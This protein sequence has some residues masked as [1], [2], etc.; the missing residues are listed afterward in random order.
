MSE[1]LCVA[2][3]ER[4]VEVKKCQLCRKCYYRQYNREPRR[5]GIMRSEGKHGREIEFIKNYFK[6]NTYVYSPCM[7]NLG[8]GTRYTPDFYDKARNVFIEVV[9]TRQAYSQNKD[10]YKLFAEFF[11]QLKLELRHPDGTIF[12]PKNP[13]Y[14][15][16]EHE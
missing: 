7:F 9:G 1:G 6:E 14:S 10:K 2:C 12:N 11:P 4:P 16:H 8:A 3:G 15:H 13:R 5:S